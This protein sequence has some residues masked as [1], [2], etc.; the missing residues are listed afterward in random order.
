M[1]TINGKEYRNLQE[2]V[3]E[4]MEDIEDLKNREANTLLST[5]IA[6]GQVLTADG[7]GGTEWASGSGGEEAVQA[8]NTLTSG[9][10]VIGTTGGDRN[11]ATLAT[12]TLGYVLTQSSGAPAWAAPSVEG[13]NVKST[14]VTSGYVLT[15]GGDG[16]SSWAAGQAAVEGADVLSTGVSSGYV[17]GA[18]GDGT[19]SWKLAATGNVTASGTLSVGS[20][21]VGLGSKSIDT[22]SGT[23]GQILYWNN[24]AAWTDPGIEVEVLG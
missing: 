8:P 3:L 13:T 20:V 17:L 10:V 12:G 4:N 18:D 16:T 22:V 6:A 1:I 7:N 23:N 9:C 15:A 14:G 24:G 21:V 19:S 11:V 5:G 2:Q